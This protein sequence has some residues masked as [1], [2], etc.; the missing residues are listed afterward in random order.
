MLTKI[1]FRFVT[2]ILFI[3]V[4]IFSLGHPIKSFAT[5]AVGGPLQ[6]G[7]LGVNIGKFI[8]DAPGTASEV[9]GEV[10]KFAL[11]VVA[12]AVATSILQTM[13]TEVINWAGSGFEGNPF[14]VE[15]QQSHMYD[16]KSDEIQLL[17]KEVS[18]NQSFGGFTS[19]PA[20][21]SLVNVVKYELKP[22]T[23]KI[24]PTISE[25][26]KADFKGDFTKGG[27]DT[28]IKQADMQNNSIG[29]RILTLSELDKRV[30]TRQ[31]TEEQKL[32][33]GAGIQAATKC[34]GGFVSDVDTGFEYCKQEVVS[35]AGKLVGDQIGQALGSSMAQST[36]SSASGDLGSIVS[37]MLSSLLT[38]L[39]YK[40]L[41]SIGGD[42]NPQPVDPF[43]SLTALVES[44]P[45][46]QTSTN[47]KYNAR[48]VVDI[49][50]ELN[51]A[52]E[53]TAKDIE[54]LVATIDTIS[55]PIL[56]LTMALDQ[57]IPG[58]DIGY[59]ERLQKYF[60]IQLTE[61]D[62]EDDAREE[63]GDYAS[64][65]AK[66]NMAFGQYLG[67]AESLI[68][69]NSLQAIK[70]R[71]DGPLQWREQVKELAKHGTTLANL[72]DVYNEKQKVLIR[73]QSIKNSIQNQSG[74][75]DVILFNDVWG[76]E[77]GTTGLSSTERESRFNSVLSSI[78][79]PPEDWA[80]L[81]EEEK[82]R[83]ARLFNEN[84]LNWNLDSQQK[85]RRLALYELFS[86]PIFTTDGSLN[87][88]EPTSTQKRDAVIAD[89]WKKWETMVNG[90]TALQEQRTLIIRNLVEARN[91]YTTERSYD[92]NNA[93]AEA[94]KASEKRLRD[95]IFSCQKARYEVINANEVIPN[96]RA[97]V[98][99]ITMPD[100]DSA[101]TQASMTFDTTPT[102][103]ISD[104]KIIKFENTLYFRANY[105]KA[106][107][108]WI[109]YSNY[110]NLDTLLN[111][112]INKS[113][114][115]TISRERALTG[116]TIISLSGSYNSASVS[117]SVVTV[118]DQDLSISSFTTSNPIYFK[119][120]AQNNLGTTCT[121][122]IQTS[123]TNTEM[124][125]VGIPEATVTQSYNFAS[126]SG[127][128]YFRPTGID[129]TSLLP[130]AST[131]VPTSPIATNVIG[132]EI[133]GTTGAVSGTVLNSG[134]SN[135]RRLLRM[136][137]QS[138]ADCPPPWTMF[139]G[140]PLLGE[141]APQFGG[142]L[143]DVAG[144]PILQSSRDRWKIGLGINAVK[145]IAIEVPFYRPAEFIQQT[146]AEG[147]PATHTAWYESAFVTPTN[148]T[149]IEA[150]AYAPVTNPV[151]VVRNYHFDHQSN[152][153]AVF[154]DFARSHGCD[155]TGFGSGT[156]SWDGVY[157]GPWCNHTDDPDNF[158][159]WYPAKPFDYLVV[160]YP[161]LKQYVR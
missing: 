46:F 58:P 79:I 53:W 139:I 33:Q 50:K 87:T 104:A 125:G 88:Q 102:V 93:K 128:N 143:P 38:D 159:M 123:S 55:G 161:R 151:I 26:E 109:E 84:A 83:I 6:G 91:T 122:Q 8:G 69:Q 90:D 63:G 134:G 51:S 73:L 9:A 95:A 35:T 113:V 54:N 144:I 121:D 130:S 37:S 85:S 116:E 150:N 140:V 60:R 82:Q 132:G 32:L 141:C 47:S 76:D 94:T 149:G 22:F 5:D 146:I 142:P 11:D 12:K 154:N 100:A 148:P 52:L 65:Y 61:N 44:D 105:T 40:G 31:H 98:L 13:A 74:N 89:G 117:N 112:A 110:N 157:Y 115:Q 131:G 28:Y 81:P 126:L 64:F 39:I 66:V 97:L 137:P 106:N 27:W 86:I 133:D 36:Q 25:I 153:N 57:C 71:F 158:Q 23:E 72:Q 2:Q 56:T 155:L 160:L 7:I 70:P 103:E 92:L 21:K 120:C 114:P 19:E 30:S 127:Y 118:G 101:T 147:N 99:P 4:I 67:N 156:A 42:S 129:L 145:T 107:V 124:N 119:I 24:Q 62:L 108:V 14:A 45:N 29:T 68:L 96:K 15:N 80:T 48:E 138:D 136:R 34:V 3:F 152:R 75:L 78:L 1:S 10:G 16:I 18:G 59:E 20:F 41:G 17:Y 77:A 111:E 43:A 135:E 49:N